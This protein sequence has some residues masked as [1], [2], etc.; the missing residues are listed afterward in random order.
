MSTGKEAIGPDKH[1]NAYGT[2]NS[3]GVSETDAVNS[4]HDDDEIIIKRETPSHSQSARD[5]TYFQQQILIPDANNVSRKLNYKLLKVVTKAYQYSFS[6][7]K[8]WAFTGPG[9]LMSIAY[10]DPGNIESDMQSGTVAGYRLLWLLM[11]STIFGLL[12]QRLSARLGTV[13]GKHLAEVCYDRYPKPLRYI[14]WI[15]VEI[16]II[17]SDMQEVI[18]TAIALYI[19]S[20]RKLPLYGGVIITICDTFTFLLLDKYGLRKLEMFFA[21]LIATMVATFG[22][23]FVRIKPS[24][25][26]MA[27]GLAIPYCNNCDSG[28][29]K[30][31]VGIIGSIIMPHNL[32]L[33][34][35]LVKSRR[36]DRSKYEEVKDANRYVFIESALA[37]GVS[38]IIN[39][40][41][42][43]VFAAGLFGARNVDI[44]NMCANDKTDL[45]DKNVFKNN[46]DAVD[47]N[48]Y[49]AG[50]FLACRF[51][52]GIPWPMY[53][54]A[55]GIFAAG[56]SSTMTGTYSGQFVMEGFLNLNWSRWK[57]VLLT[58]TIAI[59][60]TLFFVSF[61]NF[62]N[63]SGMNDLL[64]A[65]MSL[66]LPFALIPVLT[67]TSSE[68][69]MGRFKNGLFTIIMASFLSVVVISVN[70]Y[71]V[72]RFIHD[73]FGSEWYSLL[74]TILFFTYYI[75]VVL[76]LVS[77]SY[78]ISFINCIDCQVGCFLVVL[79]WKA[80]EKLPYIGKHF[81]EVDELEVTLIADYEDINQR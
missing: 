21:F 7:R 81:K 52:G 24:A 71:F 70:L 72:F 1:N 65:L 35:A 31:A 51:A 17:G 62:D 55:I 27:K 19:F 16:A 74:A 25:A 76:F 4:Y 38:L 54:W 15:M 23:E 46:T 9:F 28:A 80:V 12:V 2:I 11:W 45:I 10:L 32:Y 3:A 63:I 6:W 64:N 33:H 14:L 44:F 29:L 77:Y 75:L 34:S 39:I 60:P 68:R 59:M 13:T 56:Q 40:S 43:A 53:I 41:V 36:V 66:M 58:R 67:F 48:L 8:L 18:G 50:V 26:E 20:N 42:T 37:L 22:Y 49:K 61:K 30:Q 69:V 57:R 5:D 47:M 73:N 79:G 78:F